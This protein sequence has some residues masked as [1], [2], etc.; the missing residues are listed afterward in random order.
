MKFRCK[1]IRGDHGATI[2]LLTPCDI[3]SGVTALELR[4]GD[5]Y[6]ILGDSEGHAFLAKAFSCAALL[7]QGEFIHIPV[8]FTPNAELKSMFPWQ[9]N[10]FL[11]IILANYCSLTLSRKQA[12]KNLACKSCVEEIVERVE[13][14]PCYKYDQPWIL[15]GRL[16][17][18]R[19]KK[20]LLVSTNRDMYLAMAWSS[21][22]MTTIP[23]E[24]ASNDYAAHAHFDWDDATSKSPGLTLR[25]WYNSQDNN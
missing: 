25:Y 18:K 1:K 5:D 23:D 7:P 12:Q 4:A 20:H 10:T 2:R 17:T 13:G 22:E 6:W 16:T 24:D 14:I 19:V 9:E 3:P 8:T 11:D 15:H 21:L